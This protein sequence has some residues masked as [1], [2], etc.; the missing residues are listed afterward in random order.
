MTESKAEAKMNM[1]ERRNNGDAFQ[2]EIFKEDLHFSE[3]PERE[4]CV[5]GCNLTTTHE[6]VHH[7]D[8]AD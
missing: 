8:Q 6:G 7:E 2:R 3:D 5:T 4:K 1:T